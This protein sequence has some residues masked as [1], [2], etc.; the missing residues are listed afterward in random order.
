MRDF[1]TVYSAPGATPSVRVSVHAAIS[2][3][4]GAPVAERSF[5][6]DAPAAANRV[7]A[8]VP[9]YDAAV[10]QVLGEVVAW[11]GAAAQALPAAAPTT[12]T[13]TSTTQTVVG[14]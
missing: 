13:R 3:T 8:I 11:A 10:R 7:S 12:V 4:G 2:R 1:E 14:R 5:S 6:V 9:A